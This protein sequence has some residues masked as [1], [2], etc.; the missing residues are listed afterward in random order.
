MPLGD[1]FPALSKRLSSLRRRLRLTA[2]FRGLAWLLAVVVAVAFVGGM[3]DWWLHLPGVVRAFFLV[4]LLS[5]AGVVVQRWLVQPFR[6][7]A[8]DLSLALKVEAQYPELN[9]SLASTV[10][11]LQ[12]PADRERSIGGAMRQAAVAQALYRIERCDF[13]RIIDRRGLRAA[14]ASLLAAA[15][16][17]AG[18][19]SWQPEK[20]AIALARLAQPFGG[21]DW[22]PQT[23]LTLDPAQ[24]QRI[25][26]GDAYE[27]RADLQG[28]IPERAVV[29]LQFDNQPPTEQVVQLIRSD[30]PEKAALLVRFEP[31]RLPRNFQYQVTANDST[32]RW[33]PVAVLPPV[34]FVPLDGRPTPQIRLHFPTYTDIPPQYLAAGSGTV[35]A[36]LGTRVTLRAATDR[37]V[38][39]AWMAYHPEQPVVELGNYLSLLTARHG[40]EALTLAATGQ[41]IWGR[42]DAQLSPYE[43]GSD[44]RVQFTPWAAGTY[45]LKMVDDSGLV[46]RRLFDVRVWHDPAPAVTIERPSASQDSLLV[47]PNA[48][49][50][51]KLAIEDQQYAI[52]AVWLEVRAAKDEP[53]KRQSL[54]Q[55]QSLGSGLASFLASFAARPGVGLPAPVPPQ[56]FRPVRLEVGQRLALS[57][58][59]HADG[60][61]LKEGDV[62]V[63]QALADDFDD[64][65]LSKLPGRSHEVELRIVGVP[66]L[67]AMLHQA[68]QQVQQELQRLREQ[69][70]EALKKVDA[71]EKQWRNTG[72][73]RLEDIDNLLQAEQLQQQIRGRVGDPQ[74]GLRA[75]VAKIRQTLKD[76]NLPKSGTSERMD[77]VAQELERLAREELEQVEPLLTGAR[78]ENE[79][80][81]NQQNPDKRARGSLTQA[82][83]HQEEVERTLNDL[84]ANL[85]PF[86]STRQARAE[87]KA[88]LQEQSKLANETGQ[89]SKEIPQG[90]LPEN[91]QQK[92]LLE[93]EA[94]AQARLA[95]H[96][97]ELL[98]KMDR[99]SGQKQRE[100]EQK[101]AQA[102]D[103]ER[104]QE[105]KEA[106]AEK[107]KADNPARAQELQEEARE[108]RKD[109]ENLREAAQM[110]QDEAK[111][112]QRASEAGRAEG[113]EKQMKQAAG[114]I[115]Q[116]QLN[117]AGQQQQQSAKALEEMAKA[118]EDRREQE[119]DKL[120]KKMRQAE[121]ELERLIEDQDRLQKKVKEAQALADPKE[122]EEALQKLAR[123][124]E[125]LRKETREMAQQL[126][127]MRAGQ[128]G[129][130][131]RQA[132][133]QMDQAGQQLERGDPAAEQQDEALDRLEDALEA[134]EKA[135]EQVEDELARE[136]LIKIADQLKMLK[137]RQEALLPETERLHQK[138]LQQKTWSRD[139]LR[140][141]KDHSAAQQGLADDTNALA[142]A[143]LKD[144]LVF[145]HILDRSAKV[146]S[147][148]AGAMKQRMEKALE[149]PELNAPAE[150]SSQQL[151]LKQQKEALAL[152]NQLLD[153]LKEEEQRARAGGGGGGGGGA[154]GG[155]RGE[156]DGIPHIAQ[157]KAL[158]ALQQDVN[159]RTEDFGR[160][161][162]DAA[163]LT[164]S[165]KQELDRIRGE[166]KKIAQ[167]LDE[168]NA[169][170][171]PE[172]GKP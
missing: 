11:F 137:E 154:G 112:L 59:K 164:D 159:Q 16:I 7:P 57:Q 14:A 101:A 116:N 109:A 18:V 70:R 172:G 111:A 168:L 62:V 69:E 87:A 151:I 130:A 36:V 38:T 41:T 60:S 66:A 68:Q 144:A 147:Q 125:K 108:A 133:G 115:K 127:R 71:V 13:A 91:P 58:I 81:Q 12:Q 33:H 64:V 30:D 88:L 50:T 95:E 37:P 77:L 136:K 52:L 25:A 1:A 126:S 4:G 53:A 73:L 23:K 96:T 131:M 48:N 54:Y 145:Q 113:V 140:S 75:E 84:L 80:A 170:A 89:L 124:Q 44:L 139:L 120:A 123:E 150:E 26:R 138:V 32:T 167:L 21:P 45:V 117:R 72:K 74:E 22:P 100:A 121:K 93:Q 160:K 143:K 82:V 86:S 114:E 128:A 43:A 106:A 169:P 34:A 47:L 103:K 97:K 78:K 153:A 135:R 129:Q 46:S 8:D 61:S 24:R 63:L 35:D 110:L 31:Q 17:A 90:K 10:Q 104:L 56:R 94:E 142:E 29:R 141:L 134:L 67:E 152:L 156:S 158:K 162:P 161:H 5:G 85:D 92:A 157:L 42:S 40:G 51:L 122:R 83:Q 49:V 105:E 79:L 98:N 27:I 19:V 15:V 166:Q 163:K 65:S 146:M 119:L 102:R 76:N 149:K 39:A 9:D 165:Q 28:L 171:G 6:E 20:T 118:L 2:G 55:H 155:S 132:G 107:A 3:L 148:A 99:I